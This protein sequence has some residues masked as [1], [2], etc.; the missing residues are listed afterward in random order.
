MYS[1][2]V[3]G[4]YLLWS[5]VICGLPWRTNTVVLPVSPI[6]LDG[7]DHDRPVGVLAEVG[8]RPDRLPGLL[9]LLEEGRKGEPDR[10]E[11][12]GGDSHPRRPPGHR[13]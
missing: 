6:P 4:G 8:G 13:P 7:R 5:A 2:G 1:L 10:R 12:D 3:S 9:L 11:G